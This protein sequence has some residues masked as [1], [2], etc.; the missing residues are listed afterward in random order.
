MKNL[1]PAERLIF[2]LDVSSVKEARH[3]VKILNGVVSFFKI[4]FKS[5]T[6]VLF[7]VSGRRVNMDRFTAD[8]QVQLISVCRATGK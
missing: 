5:E 1:T 8:D 2:P 3:Y 6:P 4:V 7:I